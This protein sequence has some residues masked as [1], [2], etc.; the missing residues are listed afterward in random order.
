MV[1]VDEFFKE[2][3]VGAEVIIVSP[4]GM[5]IPYLLTF[6]FKVTNNQHKYKAFIVGLKLALTIQ[7]DRVRIQTYSHLVV[8]HL[9]ENF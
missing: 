3:E 8:N 6:E 7:A 4:E 1:T 5:K 2:L 9:N